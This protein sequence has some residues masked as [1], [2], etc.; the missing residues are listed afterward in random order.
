MDNIKTSIFEELTSGSTKGFVVKG[1]KEELIKSLIKATKTVANWKNVDSNRLKRQLNVCVKMV[2]GLL[3]G[4]KNFIVLAPTGF[5]KTILGLMVSEFMKEAIKDGHIKTPLQGSYLLTPNKFLQD[6]YQEDIN[7]FGLDKTHAQMKG[8]SNYICLKDETR[9]FA[10]RPCSPTSVFSLP[11]KEHCGKKCPYVLSRIVAE[12]SPTT[13]LNYNYYLTQMTKVYENPDVR[14]SFEPRALTVFDECHT[15]GGIVQDMFGDD[16]NFQEMA[17]EVNSAYLGVKNIY[18]DK[19]N[20]ITDMFNSVTDGFSKHIKSTED[21]LMNLANN[22]PNIIKKFNKIDTKGGND[23]KEIY[24]LFLKIIPYFEKIIKTYNEL[25]EQ[26]FPFE[27]GILLVHQFD[28]Y[29]KELYQHF[30]KLNSFINDIRWVERMY[31]EI[32]YDTMAIT[33]KIVEKN[34]RKSSVVVVRCTKIDELIKRY[35][36]KYTDVSIFMSATLGHDVKSMNDFAKSHGIQD[37]AYMIIN[38]SDFDF[39]KSPII[40]PTPAL[41]MSFKNKEANMPKLLAR[42]DKIVKLHPKEAGLIHTGSYD[43]MNS[44]EQYAFA[45]N[46]QDRFIW[47]RNATDKYKGVEQLKW[48]IKQVGWTNRILVGASLLEGVDLKDDMCRF[49]VFMKVPFASLGDEVVKKMLK[50]YG[51]EWYR[52]VTMQQVVQG[53]GRSNRH[54]NDYSAVYLMDGTFIRFLSKLYGGV[55]EIIS[56]RI[57]QKSISALFNNFEDVNTPPPITVPL[58]LPTGSLTEYSHLVNDERVLEYFQELE[59]Q[60]KDGSGIFNGAM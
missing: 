33:Y 55:P 26:Y 60:K 37:D 39:S 36:L 30:N 44:L 47:C 16:F 57:Q 11:E 49:N 52:W 43:F 58:E 38:E 59:R 2:D 4:K 46:I 32:G 24:G 19:L 41:S 15:I 42:I 20:S 18:G 53:I 54:K 10:N 25:M 27:N 14:A 13:V 40:M 9:T 34:N 3:K 22:M 5:G 29:E 28:V 31:S 48:D 8:Q 21:Y 1:S 23:Y 12:K 45:N 6:Q 51:E 7:K 35:V 50:V 56:K 17:Y